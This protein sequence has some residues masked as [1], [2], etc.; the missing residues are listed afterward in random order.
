MLTTDIG[1]ARAC[2]DVERR[3]A[4]KACCNARGVVGLGCNLSPRHYR[5]THWRQFNGQ[6]GTC[7][8]VLCRR[9]CI[10]VSVFHD[11]FLFGDAFSEGAQHDADCSSVSCDKVTLPKSKRT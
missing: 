4:R 11:S 1:T 6:A 5:K 2:V 8:P 7:S 9:L 10:A 3:H